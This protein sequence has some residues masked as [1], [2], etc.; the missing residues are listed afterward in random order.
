MM[1]FFII[2]YNYKMTYYKKYLKYKNKYAELKRMQSM[3]GGAYEGLRYLGEGAESIVYAMPDGKALKIIKDFESR[4]KEEEKLVF[5]AVKD[6]PNFPK[7]YAMGNCKSN[8][9]PDRDMTKF[10]M[11]EGDDYQYVIMDII[12]GKDML[13]IF[14][15]KFK[16]YINLDPAVL[17]LNDA[18]L[19]AK[20]IEFETFYVEVI[21]K[22]V[23]ALKRANDAVR[24][25]HNDL[26]F[27]NCLVSAAGVP[28]IIDFGQSAINVPV[29][30]L[31]CKDI[32]SYVNSFT[33]GSYCN[34]KDT[35]LK[36]YADEPTL[37][38]VDKCSKNCKALLTKLVSLPRMAAIKKIISDSC[39]PYM[40]TDIK[41]SSMEEQFSRV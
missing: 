37:A 29:G 34:R 28:T 23:N 18:V 10:C 19:N 1:P 9:K 22:M 11:E 35:I 25:R 40:N 13:E 36:T 5:D 2:M 12:D 32:A 38:F 26:D 16:D 7:I 24:F 8:V 17:N 41:L 3:R 21:K 6:I 31:E 4:I 15:D 30:E 39:V 14:Y 27:R 33:R 20:M